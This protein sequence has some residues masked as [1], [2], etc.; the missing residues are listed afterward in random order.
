MFFKCCSLT[1]LHDEL[2]EKAPALLFCNDQ[3]STIVK[4]GLIVFDYYG[5]GGFTFPVFNFVIVV[6]VAGT[7]YMLVTYFS[8][9]RGRCC[10]E[11]VGGMLMH[12]FIILLCN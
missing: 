12:I 4:V 2:E 3:F 9:N 6:Q 8:K 7:L 1:C 11:K 10:M 5:S